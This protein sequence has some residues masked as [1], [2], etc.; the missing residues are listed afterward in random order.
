M[1]AHNTAAGAVLVIKSLLASNQF[2]G[3][4]LAARAIAL[5]TGKTVHECRTEMRAFVIRSLAESFEKGGVK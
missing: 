4:E 1:S 2:D 3:V 5:E